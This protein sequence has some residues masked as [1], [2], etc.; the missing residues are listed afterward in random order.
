MNDI[1]SYLRRLTGSSSDE[2]FGTGEFSRDGEDCW[3]V[4]AFFTEPSVIM[5]NKHTGEKTIPFSVHSPMADRFKEINL[6]RQL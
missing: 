6:V 3:K 4:H 5:K 1:D 2:N